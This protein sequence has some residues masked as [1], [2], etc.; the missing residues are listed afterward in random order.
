MDQKGIGNYLSFVLLSA[1][2]Q[3]CVLA[4]GLLAWDWLQQADGDAHAGCQDGNHG[5]E[6]D[7]TEEEEEEAFAEASIDPRTIHESIYVIKA[8]GTDLTG[9]QA[10][11]AGD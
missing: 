7:S 1:L 5:D 2:A 4:R 11:V 6:V 9:H 10:H 3:S 8:V